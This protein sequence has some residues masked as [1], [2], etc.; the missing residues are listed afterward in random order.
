MATIKDVAAAAG[1]SVSTASR[2]L[3]N[4]PR[5]SAATRQ[6]V[7]A[8]AVKLNY[9]PNY[10]ARS[11]TMGE[12]NIVGLIFPV[13]ADDAPA[14]PFQLDLMRGVA[15]ALAPYDY[16]TAVAIG[17]TE[18]ELLGHVHSLVQ[19]S[20]VRRFIVFYSRANDPVTDFLRDQQLN[21]IVVG[22][23]TAG[24][25]DRFVDNNNQAAGAAAV[26]YLSAHYGAQ[27]PL[28]VY[29]SHN[30]LYE[31]ARAQG[32]AE[33]LGSDQDSLLTLQLSH[34]DETLPRTPQQSFDS[35]IASDDVV[36]L[37]YISLMRSQSQSQPSLPTM[38]FNNSRLLNMVLPTVTKIDMLPRQL[39]QS[40][41][42]LLFDNQGAHNHLVGFK[43]CPSVE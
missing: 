18:T 24:L 21:F 1:V 36:L 10:T 43:I 32:I 14:N 15:A 11:L 7:K 16:E 23:P 37:R 26:Q 39:G 42:R 17:R 5:I 28:Y 6:R 41:V 35:I 30:W 29:S 33:A 38:C 12:S 20:K 9:Q 25:T 34:E 8:V 4:N 2:A 22:Q 13:T 27:H 31:Q 19:Q 40:A 3:N